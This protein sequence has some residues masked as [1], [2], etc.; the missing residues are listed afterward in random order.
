MRHT[1]DHYI[2]SQCFVRQLRWLKFFFANPRNGLQVAI[3]LQ[4]THRRTPFCPAP[5][6]RV[7][8]VWRRCPRGGSKLPKAPGTAAFLTPIAAWTSRLA[9]PVGSCRSRDVPQAKWAIGWTEER[10]GQPTGLQVPAFH[11][12][13]ERSFGRR[14]PSENPQ[15]PAAPTPDPDPGGRRTSGPKLRFIYF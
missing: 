12:P 7:G 8:I 10:V 15:G 4:N 14:Q 3:S 6:P 1:D 9:V 13:G 11:T 5:L 2:A